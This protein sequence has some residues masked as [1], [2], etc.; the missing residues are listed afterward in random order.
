LPVTATKDKRVV[1]V[2]FIAP[3]TSDSNNSESEI[4]TY[5]RLIAGKLEINYS[6]HII[7]SRSSPM[8][9]HTD[10]LNYRM[11]YTSSV[12]AVVEAGV[13]HAFWA[14]FAPGSRVLPGEVGKPECLSE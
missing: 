7:R 10:Q 6:H 14:H 9:P 12:R 2:S 8:G 4:V 3:P 5:V 13:M 11:P 1:R